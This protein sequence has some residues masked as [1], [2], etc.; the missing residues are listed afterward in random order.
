[1]H[2]VKQALIHQLITLIQ[3]DIAEAL[4]AAQAAHD[5]ATHEQ[6]KAE[7]QY[8]TLGLEHAYLAHGQSQRIENMQL[9]ILKLNGLLKELSD[10]SHEFEEA[11]LG[12]II[13][14]ADESDASAN[15]TLFFVPAGGGYTLSL[16]SA[17]LDSG[18]SPF[19]KTLTPDA[20]LAKAC[21]GLGEG[22]VIHLNHRSFR[23]C[24]IH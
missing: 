23:I 3:Q 5:G 16:A 17:L 1:M 24:S 11:Y 8:D 15:T 19:I 12:A 10:E 20:P 6:S 14:L 9:S 4:A 13:E 2:H 21:W 22:D 7:T 18:L